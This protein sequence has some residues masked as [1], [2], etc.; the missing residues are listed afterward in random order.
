MLDSLDALKEAI[1]EL[2]DDKEAS[3]ISQEEFLVEV[4]QGLADVSEGS[5]T[6]L[7]SVYMGS[8]LALVVEVDDG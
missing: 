3:I 8:L 6:E 5:S 1:S 2:L 7:T 4:Y